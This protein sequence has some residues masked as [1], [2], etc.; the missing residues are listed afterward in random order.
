MA[1]NAQSDL[2]KFLT[3]SSYLFAANAPFI[4]ELYENYLDDPASVSEDWRAFFDRLNQAESKAGSGEFDHRE[5]RQSLV[6]AV[7][8]VKRT[9]PTTTTTPTRVSPAAKI[10]PVQPADRPVASAKVVPGIN[11]AKENV[12]HEA[13]ILHDEKQVAVLQLINAYRFRGHQMAD[14]DP[15]KLRG[16]GSV[17]DLDPAYHNLYEADMHKKFNTGSLV[18]PETAT[19]EEILN[20]LQDT[21]CGHIG[22]EYMHINSTT[23]KRW[24]QERLE[25]VGGRPVFDVGVKKQILERLVAAE[26]LEKFLHVKYV[27]QKRFSLEGGESLIPLLDNLIQRSGE[28]N[29]KEVVVGMAHRGRLNV[30]VNIVGKSPN[31]LFREFEGNVQGGNGSGDVKYHQGFSSDVET[32]G[33]PVHLT[34]AFNPSHLEIINPVV[35]GSVRAR[36]HRRRDTEGNQVLPVLIHGDAAFAGQGVVMES[37]QMSQARGF[38][39]GGTVHI[40]INNQI[41]FTTSNPLDTRS[42]LHCTEVVKIVQAPIFHVHADDPEAVLFVT[43]LALDFRMAFNKEVLIDLICYRRHG[44]NEADEPKATQPMMYK[45]IGNHPLITQV[46]TDQLIAEGVITQAEVDKIKQDFRGKLDEGQTVAPNIMLGVENRLAIDWTLYNNVDWNTAVNTGL[47]LKDIKRLTDLACEVPDGFKLHPTVVKILDSRRN[48]AEGAVRFDW[49]FAENMAYA[50]LLEDGYSIRLTGQDSGRGTFFHRHVALHNQSNGETYLPLQHLSKDQPKFITIDSLLSE[51]AVLGFE[52]GFSSTDANTLVIW[53]AQ[54]GDF[55]NGAQVVM[56]QFI[57]SGESKW[58]RYC[59]ITLFLPHGY[60]G[61]GPEHSSARLE[62]YLQLCAEENMQVCVPST[63][64][65][66]FH[67]IRRQM[68]RP[69]RKPLIVMTPKSLLRHKGATSSLEEIASGTGFQNVIAEVDPLEPDKVECLIVCSGK[70]YYE[71]LQARRDREIENIAII[72]I[73]QLYPFPAEEFKEQLALYPNAHLVRWC[74]E[75]PRNQGAWRYIMKRLLDCMSS[76]QEISYATRP[77]SASPAVGYLQKHLEQQK[78]IIDTALSIEVESSMVMPK[79]KKEK[80]SVSR[81]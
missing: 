38:S 9:T 66:M 61:Q 14:T 11:V 41:G 26:G 2:L 69:L 57:S 21:Y 51:E 76:T 73:E 46:Y 49:G 72:R 22:S 7:P 80:K 35:G 74:Q 13:A 54:F 70:L 15:I 20:V 63:P 23:E 77:P 37:L 16:A 64:A 1:A 19:L 43:Q 36:Q 78:D 44:H 55:A 48:M 45:K 68:L 33:G 42:T 39:T 17:L 75:E 59:G 60:D 18:G 52:Y 40:V 47:E 34:L 81:G 62:R 79:I 30:L 8:G 12:S 25:S 28:K 3:D 56:D 5:I 10:A 58:G 53:E 6:D 31:D 50:G 29:I 32:P 71:L 24:I 4:E 27:G 65:Q 67:M